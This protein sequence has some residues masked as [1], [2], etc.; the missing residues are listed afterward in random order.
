MSDDIPNPEQLPSSY[1][2]RWVARIHGKVVAQGDTPEQ[3]LRASQQ[4]RHKERPEIVFMFSLPPLIKRVMDILPANQE[5]YLVGGAVRDFLLSRP[6]PDLD[7]ALPANGISLARTVANALG[8]AFLPLDD[9]RDT[10]RVIFTDKDGS[11]VF[12]DFAVYRGADL[13]ED[14]NNNPLEEQRLE[15]GISLPL[16]D[17]G[18]ARG[19]IK[20]AES[21]QEVVRTTIEQEEIDFNQEIFLKVARF[22]MQFEQVNISA[23]SDTVAQKG[24]DITKARYLIGKISITDLNI[25]QTEADNSKSNYIN[26]LWVYWRNYYDLRRLTLYDFEQDLPIMVDYKDLL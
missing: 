21:N 11:R 13:I 15:L 23:K 14:L 7:F 4:S 18:V 17:W 19:K 22:N 5:I 2:G 25:A 1:A 10:G 6:S 12:L 24:Y 26:T 16:L 9:E 3:A 20:M 8:A